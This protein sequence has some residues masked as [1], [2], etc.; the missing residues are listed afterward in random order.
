MIQLLLLPSIPT[1]IQR[2]I[3]YRLGLAKKAVKNNTYTLVWSSGEETLDTTGRKASVAMCNKGN[4]LIS[5][6]NSGRSICH[7]GKT[8][9]HR[10]TTI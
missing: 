2:K 8:H 1:G 4:V 6:S 9:V 10:E 5:Y 3:K 7:I